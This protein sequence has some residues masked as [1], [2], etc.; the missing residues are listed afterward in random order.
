MPKQRNRLH[1]GRVTVMLC[2][3]CCIGASALEAQLDK[4]AA[5]VFDKKAE[6]LAKWWREHWR[7]HREEIKKSDLDRISRDRGKDSKNDPRALPEDVKDDLD[8][9]KNPR[10]DAK[11][12]KVL[13]KCGKQVLVKDPLKRAVKAGWEAAIA[14]DKQP[15]VTGQVVIEAAC[16]AFNE[17][18]KREVDAISQHPD[19]KMEEILK[20]VLKA[21]IVDPVTYALTA[22]STSIIHGQSEHDECLMANLMH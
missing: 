4:A 10:E 19:D 14:A 8:L 6:E 20:C 15:G 7:A 21:G 17:K 12:T 1:G 5:D 16:K 22:C 18:V 2:V 13:K 9:A 11:I 3:L